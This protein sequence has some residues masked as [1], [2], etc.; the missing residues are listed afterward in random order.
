MMMVQTMEVMMAAMMVVALEVLHLLVVKDSVK[1]WN[2]LIL[3]IY[4]VKERFLVLSEL[5]TMVYG[6]VIRRI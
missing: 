3:L 6:L 1:I 2:L 5:F 4:Q